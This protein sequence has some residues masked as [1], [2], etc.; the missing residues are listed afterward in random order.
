MGSDFFDLK[1]NNFQYFCWR[2]RVPRL[3]FYRF[4]VNGSLNSVHCCRSGCAVRFAGHALSLLDSRPSGFTAFCYI[5]IA[6][7][8]WPHTKSLALRKGLVPLCHS[9]CPEPTVADLFLPSI[10]S[11]ALCGNLGG[12]PCGMPPLRGILGSSGVMQTELSFCFHGSMDLGTILSPH[13]PTNVSLSG[14]G[15]YQT[16]SHAWMA[17]K[18]CQN[19]GLGLANHT[20]RAK[21]SFRCRKCRR[22]PTSFCGRHAPKR[23]P[24]IDLSNHLGVLS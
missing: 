10:A 3:L 19:L 24:T 2:Q 13:L 7:H 12:E 4:T 15:L 11:V 5:H 18:L 6:Q 22:W 23:A 21:R 16:Q 14:F 1:K 8:A 9:L 17:P 20:D